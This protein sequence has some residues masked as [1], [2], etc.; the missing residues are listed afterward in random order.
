MK[1][2]G[3]PRIG[4]IISSFALFGS[5]ALLAET[6][7]GDN[8]FD[9]STALAI[10]TPTTGEISTEDDD[11]YKIT[12][13]DGA[14]SIKIEFS[15][16]GSPADSHRLVIYDKDKAQISS[17]VTDS[18]TFSASYTIARAAKDA[19]YYVMIDG[20]SSAAAS[21]YDLNAIAEPEIEV[22]VKGSPILVDGKSFSCGTIKAGKSRVVTFSIKNIGVNALGRLE[23]VKSTFKGES[24][25]LGQPKEMVLAPGDTTTFTVTFKP[26]SKGPKTGA[27]RI[28]SND[29]DEDPY[30][31]PLKGRGK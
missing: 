22:K 27:I 12:N 5:G 10:N 8:S 17:K 16:Q 28:L 31:I 4:L 29:A 26:T 19:V 23:T 20:Q 24:F 25:K 15:F 6:E 14:T 1:V 9:G 13:T 21:S 30:D 11:Y 3:I 2:S 7:P 18:T